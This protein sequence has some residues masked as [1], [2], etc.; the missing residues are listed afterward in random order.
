MS[1]VER[2]VEGRKT[3]I[4]LSVIGIE[5]M[6]KTNSHKTPAWNCYKYIRGPHLV[7][8]RHKYRNYAQRAAGKLTLNN[9]L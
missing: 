2:E 1:D 9:L 6:D 3:D 7:N 8:S 4:E 5:I